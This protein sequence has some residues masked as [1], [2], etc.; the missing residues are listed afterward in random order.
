MDVQAPPAQALAAPSRPASG[1][2]FFFF[3]RPAAGAQA[4][5]HSSAALRS[6]FA[7][8]SP[9]SHPAR[10]LD[11]AAVAALYQNCLKLASENK[12]TA[13]NTWALPLIDHMADLVAGG[14]PGG[15]GGPGGEG[16]GT[17]FQRASLT[18]AAGVS[19]YAHRVDAVHGDVFRILGGLGRP[20]GEGVGGKE[21]GGNGAGGEDGED[22]AGDDG[23]DAGGDANARRGRRGKGAAASD[24]AATLAS[25][26][27]ITAPQFD[28]AFAVDP[29]F[30][31]TAAQFD[32]GG[33]GG[34]LLAGLPLDAGCCLAF[35]SSAVPT[36]S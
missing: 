8:S 18:L 29:L 3:F 7:F 21:D 10:A 34:L 27:D 5:C 11:A 32:E 23:D 17:D 16:D 15:A 31:R 14:G 9:P 30:Q 4:A 35:D 24:P 36:S 33:A 1:E 2:F 26:E 19:I 25:R 6:P 22:E 28:L 20:A 13:K 12:I